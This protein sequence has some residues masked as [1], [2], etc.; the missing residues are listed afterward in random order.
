MHRNLPHFTSQHKMARSYCIVHLFHPVN[1]EKL[2]SI[3]NDVNNCCVRGG[4]GFIDSRGAPGAE[5]ASVPTIAKQ[6][7]SPRPSPRLLACSL[8]PQLRVWKASAARD[9]IVCNKRCNEVKV[10]LARV[11]SQRRRKAAA[12]QTESTSRIIKSTMSGWFVGGQRPSCWI[13]HACQYSTFYFF[14]KTIHWAF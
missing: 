10:E 12:R 2:T 8:M 7:S 14:F 5:Q 11:L 9:L 3:T 1:T 13:H 6:T 4:W